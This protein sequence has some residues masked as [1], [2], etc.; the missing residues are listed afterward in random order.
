[1]FR[2]K[3]KDTII[4]MVLMFGIIAAAH[5]ESSLVRKYSMKLG[6]AE[7]TAL[8]DMQFDMDASLFKNADPAVLKKYMPNG[9]V[10][11]SDNVFVIKSGK[12]ITLVDAGTGEGGSEKGKA[13]D[14]VL[15]AGI[16]PEAVDIILLTHAH[17]DHI[18]GLVNKGK[19]VFPNAKLFISKAELASL[20]GDERN[21]IDIYKNRLTAFLPGSTIDK[22][23]ISV[24]MAGH[25]AGS[26]GFLVESEG[27]KLLMAG[28]VLHIAVVQFP[29]PEYSVSYDADLEKAALTRKRILSKASAEGIM[30]AG[31]HI[32]FPGI[33][34]VKS[35]KE[36][37]SFKPVKQDF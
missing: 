36:G 11:A 30:I 3:S 18:G 29:H 34:T 12:K 32:L 6:K 20:S 19:A 8:Q 33:G 17:F 16:K 1:M 21:I 23:I 35:E 31:A 28:D 27:E 2:A 26:S 4:S 7:I 14:L 37:F 24:D 15:S 9:K 13:A 5:S 10:P 22:G 25:T